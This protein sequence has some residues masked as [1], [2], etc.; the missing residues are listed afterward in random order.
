[1]KKFS[2]ILFLLASFT[3]YAQKSVGI[4]IPLWEKGAPGF[5]NRKNE[6]EKAKDWWVK[7]V[8]NPSITAFLPDPS[9]ATGAA[10]IICP[11][12]GHRELVYN[13][14]G[15]KAAE[16]FNKIGVAAFVLKYR[17]YR[18]EQSPY[19]K[20]NTISDAYRA[21]EILHQR[22]DE[23]MLNKDK[24]GIMGFSA[25]G[26]L[27]AWT[28]YDYNQKSNENPYK[29]DFIIFIYPGPGAVPSSLGATPPPAFLLVANDDEG[30]SQPVLDIAAMYRKTKVPVEVHI[31]AQGKHGFNMGDRSKLNSLNTWPVRL[32]DWVKDS[33][34]L[35]K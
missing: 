2:F 6:P 16:V 34:I 20:E 7:N 35:D 31:Y 29:P 33:G 4:K 3:I 24:I 5:E 19:T 15:A 10:V 9:I 1:M 13:E 14:E 30:C 23:W 26:E 22:A 27:A 8:H 11:G 17:L 18:E 12:G 25:G 28:T 21:L 32:I